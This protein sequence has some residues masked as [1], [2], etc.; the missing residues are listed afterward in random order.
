MNKFIKMLIMLMP[1]LFFTMSALAIDIEDLGDF[2]S[3]SILMNGSKNIITQE[4]KDVLFSKKLTPNTQCLIQQIKKN[5]LDNVELLLSYGINP[6]ESYMTQYP[7]YVAAK[8]NNFA[9][10][11]MLHE[12][13]AKLDRG[14]YSELYEALKNKNTQMAQYLLDNKANVN[15]KDSVTDNTILYMAL[16]NNMLDIAQQIINKGA[17]ADRKSVLI[18]KKKKLQY[19]IKDKI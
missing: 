3:R 1:M 2:S 15:Y 19:L 18:I 6:N 12:Y 14:F 11:K 17:N 10:L 13:G 4:Q 16:K 8:E 5:K 9:I 7:I